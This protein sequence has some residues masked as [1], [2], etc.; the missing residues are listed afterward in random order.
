VLARGLC[1]ALLV[2]HPPSLDRCSRRGSNSSVPGVVSPPLFKGGGDPSVRAAPD[3]GSEKAGLFRGD[4]VSALG[5]LPWVGWWLALGGWGVVG[6]EGFEECLHVRGE[7]ALPLELLVGDRV[8]QLQA[9]GVEGLA[10]EGA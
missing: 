8:V 2:S 7:G 6:F 9:G 4:L 3:V 1:W 10:F 5:W